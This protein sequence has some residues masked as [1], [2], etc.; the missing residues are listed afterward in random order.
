MKQLM[1]FGFCGG[2]GEQGMGLVTG[3]DGVGVFAGEN[4][5][6]GWGRRWS[7]TLVLTEGII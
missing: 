1:V 7:L 4:R 6:S 5:P 2:S 3:G